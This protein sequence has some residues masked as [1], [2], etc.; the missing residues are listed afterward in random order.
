[1]A[2]IAPTANTSFDPSEN[3]GPTTKKHFYKFTANTSMSNVRTNVIDMLNEWAIEKPESGEGIVIVDAN[4][5]A[6]LATAGVDFLTPDSNTT[7]ANTA[8]ITL[9]DAD[10]GYITGSGT[11]K[12]TTLE[13]DTIINIDSL[14]SPNGIF[15]STIPTSKVITIKTNDTE[16][17]NI[18]ANG[19]ATFASISA[20]NITATGTITATTIKGNFLDADGD[21]YKPYIA[22]ANTPES[23]YNNRLW[24]NTTTGII[25]YYNGSSWVK[26]G[27]VFK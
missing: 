20:N 11:A 14:S 18:A 26:L 4:G 3:W 17:G 16:T 13:A 19:D 2:I 23:K 6:T 21:D 27:A 10:T 9:S 24:I 15:S 25:S 8:G 5:K 12:F 7:I 1:M 22:T